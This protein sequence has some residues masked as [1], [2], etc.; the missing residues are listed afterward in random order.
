MNELPVTLLLIT[1]FALCIGSFLNV[2]IYRVPR[3]LSVSYPSRSFCPDCEQQLS[4]WENI[5]VLSWILLRT[6]C[7]H[8]GAPISGQY[9]LVE[10]LSVCAAI[11]SYLHFGLTPTGFVLYALTASLIAI[12]FID[13]A[14]KIIPNVISFPGMTL[15][16]LLGIVSQYSNAFSPP[17][18]QSAWDSLLGFLLGGGF[19]YVVGAAYQLGTGRIGLGGGD[20]KLLAF[21][22]ATLGYESVIPTIFAGSLVGALV[23]LLTVAIQGGGR[24]T[25]IPFG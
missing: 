24:H 25:E 2:V 9:P 18:T 3:K 1:I 7:R 23:G 12:T 19:F 11:A 17:L 21:T 22:G 10:L 13:L 16:L 6:K 8:C 5:P 4:W 20:I 14:F 15:G